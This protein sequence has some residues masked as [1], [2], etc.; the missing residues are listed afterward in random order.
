MAEGHDMEARWTSR[1]SFVA[2]GNQERIVEPGNILLLPKTHLA[3]GLSGSVVFPHRRPHRHSLLYASL[4]MPHDQKTELFWKCCPDTHVH[5]RSLFVQHAKLLIC[6][7][8]CLTP[9]GRVRIRFL[10]PVR[11]RI[12]LHRQS[13]QKTK[14]QRP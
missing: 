4:I 1:I 11:T 7:Y 5:F 2:T 8:A 9:S 12:R 13:Y 14:E 10:D 3:K 6:Q